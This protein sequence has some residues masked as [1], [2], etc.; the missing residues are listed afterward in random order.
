METLV[1][2]PQLE[3]TAP[4]SRRV[5]SKNEEEGRKGEGRFPLLLG[6]GRSIRP[7]TVLGYTLLDTLNHE[8]RFPGF[9]SFDYDVRSAKEDDVSDLV[10]SYD[11]LFAPP[12][13]DPPRWNE[14]LASSRLSRTLSA[15]NSTVLVAVSKKQLVG[16]CT[17]Y[18][19]LE[20]VRFGQRAWVEDLAVDP[21]RRSHGIGKRLLDEAKAWARAH[22]AERL[23]LDTGE[24]RVDAQRFYEREGPSYRSKSYG[25][26]L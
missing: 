10:R 8:A 22:G 4:G 25:W 18:L 24:A 26:W 1:A 17:V 20:S 6:H 23:A 15:V 12:G 16:F 3:E 13:S 9:V 5:R 2:D 11:W 21:N 14:R 19:D 7:K